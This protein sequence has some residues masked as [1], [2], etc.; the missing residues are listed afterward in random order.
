[1]EARVSQQFWKSCASAPSHIT[2][3]RASSTWR[4]R[5][6][7]KASTDTFSCLA[8]TIASRSCP[9]SSPY[10]R[11]VR[12][13]MQLSFHCQAQ[14]TSQVKK[15]IKISL[16]QPSR[17]QGQLEVSAGS[18]CWKLTSAELLPLSQT[19]PSPHMLH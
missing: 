16:L 10:Q 6:P 11:L 8:D 4:A 2:K 1:M 3:T 19:T 17:W 12:S 13:P 14:R 7:A 18:K 9:F 15:K 5:A